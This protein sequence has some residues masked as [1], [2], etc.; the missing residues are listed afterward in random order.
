[1]N[2]HHDYHAGNFADVLKHVVLAR[3]LTYMKQKPKPFRVIDTH[4]GAGLYDLEG[5]EAAK[6]AEWQDGIA[7]IFD[8][9][10]PKYVAE[11]LEPYLDAVR[12][13][14]GAGL[15]A[16]LKYY[17]GSPLIAR[18]LMRDDDILVANELAEAEFQRLKQEL[19]RA[20]STTVL[21]ID[22]RHAV[23][24]L[25]PPK[26]RRGLVLIDP[27]F[28]EK[29]EF[30]D[31]ATAVDDAMARFATGT[32]LIWYPIKD[33]A[34]ADRFV[35]VATAKP[36]VEFLDVR[37]AVSKPFPGLGLTASGVLVLNP[38]FVLRAELETLMPC[39]ESYLAEGSGSSF[40]IRIGVQ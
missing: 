19:R 15:K 28:E 17:P 14:N 8:A 23:K 7:R 26:E 18:H 36:G 38:P 1:M 32:Y 5:A 2:Y 39:L 33:E 3:V 31:L 10:L 27:P 25:L 35:A 12:S 16:G 6:T 21:N 29:S 34:A 9:D 13:V 22:A 11:L 40:D 37:L 4:A 30:A 20:K 24:S